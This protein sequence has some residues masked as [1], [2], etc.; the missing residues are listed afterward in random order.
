M[1]HTDE[2]SSHTVLKAWLNLGCYMGAWHAV[3]GRC[4]CARHHHHLAHPPALGWHP[5]ASLQSQQLALVA[6]GCHHRWCPARAQHFAGYHTIRSANGW[7]CWWVQG[8]GS[9]MF[10]VSRHVRTRSIHP[11]TTLHPVNTQPRY[12][13]TLFSAAVSDTRRC[14]PPH[15][16]PSCSHCLQTRVRIRHFSQPHVS[17]TL[18][19]EKPHRLSA[20]T[21]LSD[22]F[23]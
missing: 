7:L 1:Q 3:P 2:A 18:L 6:G 20:G 4:S 5:D 12:L 17:R 21:R 19:T 9:G 23:S 22:C 8:S 11:V 10:W 14:A 16:Q 15:A 13:G